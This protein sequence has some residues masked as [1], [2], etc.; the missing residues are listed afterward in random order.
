MCFSLQPLPQENRTVR[1]QISRFF[2][3]SAFFNKLTPRFH[4]LAHQ[5]EDGLALGNVFQRHRDQSAPLPAAKAATAK[6]GLLLPG[7]APRSRQRSPISELTAVSPSAPSTSRTA[8]ACPSTIPGSYLRRQRG[9]LPWMPK[10]RP[11]R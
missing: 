10:S 8:T 11:C 2:T 7:L 3:S 4:I 9:E 1:D 5:R 6:L